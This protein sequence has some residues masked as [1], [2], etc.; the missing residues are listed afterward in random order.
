MPLMSTSVGITSMA[1]HLKN[2]P[3]LDKNILFISFFLE[4]VFKSVFRAFWNIFMII[5]ESHQKIIFASV[6]RDMGLLEACYGW[7]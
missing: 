6:R 5:L 3:W 2:L 7:K 4:N 1:T